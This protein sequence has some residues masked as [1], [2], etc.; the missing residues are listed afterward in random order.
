MERLGVLLFPLV[1]LQQ[2]NFSRYDTYC[3]IAVTIR[4][5]SKPKPSSFKIKHVYLLFLCIWKRD[6]TRNVPSWIWMDSVLWYHMLLVFFTNIYSHTL[7]INKLWKWK[8]K[9]KLFRSISPLRGCCTIRPKH[10]M[11]QC[12]MMLNNKQSCNRC[13]LALW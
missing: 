13:F 7:N 6:I 1:V 5:M 4:Y 11:Q 2:Y 10:T 3:D 9:I 12:T 8:V